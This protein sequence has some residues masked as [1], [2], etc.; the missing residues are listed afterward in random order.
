MPVYRVEIE[1]SAERD[2]DRLALTLF[3][4]VMTRIAALCDEP[5]PHGAQKLS[6]VDAYRIRVGDHRVVYRINDLL[7]TVA[8]TRVRH[9][10]EVY[11][12]LR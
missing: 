4:R 9:R 12:K 7:R 6:G 11:R 1:A 5:R 10:R 2:L 3:Q 8:V